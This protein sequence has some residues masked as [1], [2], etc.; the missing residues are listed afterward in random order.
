[1]TKTNRIY[2]AII[3]GVIIVALGFWWIFN[4]RQSSLPSQ[5]NDPTPQEQ[6]CVRAGCSSELCVSA[7]QAG[8]IITTCEYKAN[9]ACYQ[10]ANCKRLSSGECG[11]EDTPELKKCLEEAKSPKL[12][13][14]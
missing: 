3:V 8:Q 13:L 9:Y 4:R 5:H 2:V 12:I 1:M 10:N 11:F 7:D 14:E 6:A